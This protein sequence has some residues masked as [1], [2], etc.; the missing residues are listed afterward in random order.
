MAQ[1]TRLS[2][3][4]KSLLLDTNYVDWAGLHSDVLLS[5]AAHRATSH[6]NAPPRSKILTAS[7]LRIFDQFQGKW[8]PN[9]I[10]DDPVKQK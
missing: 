3:E 6:N 1:T 4:E 8:F 5:I 9:S 10:V 2:D 7:K